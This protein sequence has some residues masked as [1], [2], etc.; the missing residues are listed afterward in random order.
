M[1]TLMLGILVW[2]GSSVMYQLDQNS[3]KME[4]FSIQQAVTNAELKTIGKQLE[5]LPEMGKQVA[6]NTLRHATTERR[7]DRLEKYR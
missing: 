5:T 2:L 6:V 4:Q 3:D 1:P 7:L